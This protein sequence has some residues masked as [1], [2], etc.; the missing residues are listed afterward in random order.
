VSAT[1]VR[2]RTIFK[3]R[4]RLW[5]SPAAST[6]IRSISSVTPPLPEARVIKTLVS[7]R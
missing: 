6:G 3:R 5:A 2:P 1:A 7:G 4:T